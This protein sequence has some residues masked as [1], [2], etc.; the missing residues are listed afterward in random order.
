MSKMMKNIAVI[1]HPLVSHYLT[2][3]RDKNTQS[4]EFK[5]TVDILSYILASVYYA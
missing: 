1:E 3:L 5:Q 4:F 2:I